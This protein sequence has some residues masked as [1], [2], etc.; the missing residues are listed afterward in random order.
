M[1][2][3]A[4]RQKLHQFIDN[5]EA[6]KVKAIYTLFEQEIE[7][8]GVEYTNELKAELDRGYDYYK[9]GGKMVSGAQADKQIKAIL[10][11]GKRK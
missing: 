5:I 9:K 6:K 3:I 10:Q 4:I 2:T 8:E 1:Q 7:Q 11:A